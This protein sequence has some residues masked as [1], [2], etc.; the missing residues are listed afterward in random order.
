WRPGPGRVHQPAEATPASFV[1][2]DLLSV[3]SQDLSS[4][5]LSVRQAKL[6]KLL[7]AA[8]P[9]S[10]TEPALRKAP[11]LYLTPR[12]TDPDEAQSWFVDLERIGCDGIIAKRADGAYEPDKRA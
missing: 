1:A 3:D 8:T 9:K 12:T 10:P 11:C 2:F 4:E 7:D 5:A 6:D